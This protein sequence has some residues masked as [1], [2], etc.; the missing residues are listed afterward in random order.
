MAFEI[1]RLPLLGGDYDIA[2]GAGGG[3][4]EPE[5]DRV[6]HFSVA[7]TQGASGVVDLRGEW[8]VAA[9]AEAPS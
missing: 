8:R 9:A 5:P 1:P 6:L 4:D 3:D 2:L 7:E